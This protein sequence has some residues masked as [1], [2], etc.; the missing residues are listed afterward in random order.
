MRKSTPVTL[1]VAGLAALA[2]A[3][4]SSGATTNGAASPAATAG[5]ST[6]AS[7]LAD[8]GIPPTPNPEAWRAYI[9]ALKAIDPDIVHGKEE[10]AVDRGRDQCGSVKDSNDQ[11]KLVDLTNLRFTSPGHPNGFGKAKATRIL[12]AVRRYICPTY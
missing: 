9:A 2:L 5:P 7:A 4:G 6:Y 12:A 1:T 11:A 8:A 10:K 3:C